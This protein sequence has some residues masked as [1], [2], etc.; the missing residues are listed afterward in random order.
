[1]ICDINVQQMCNDM[2]QCGNTAHI[3]YDISF[4]YWRKCIF[5]QELTE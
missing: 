4:I 5:P 2:M 1:M 3:T